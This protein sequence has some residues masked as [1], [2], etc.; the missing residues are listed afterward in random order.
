M[1]KDA[2]SLLK[3][4]PPRVLAA[5]GVLAG[6]IL[7]AAPAPAAAR[8]LPFD[9]AIKRIAADISK[10][11]PSK[12]RVLV[13]DL[14]DLDGRITHFGRYLSDKLQ[15]GL[16]KRKTDF[17]IVDR[18]K[19][20][21]SLEELTLQKAGLMDESTMT[22][23]GKMLGASV[24]VYGTVT[25]LDDSIDIDVKIRDIETGTS[26][27]GTSRSLKKTKR[28]AHLVR[29]IIKSERDKEKELAEYRERVLKEIEEDRLKRIAAIKA[30][31]EEKR[32]KLTELDK[33]IRL[34]STAITEYEEKVLELKKSQS[35]LEA[36]HSKIDRLNREVPSKLKIGMTRA[37]VRSVLELERKLG[38][39]LDL[40]TCFLVGRYFLL[41]EGDVLGSVVLS[42]SVGEFKSAH[43]RSFFKGTL[44]VDS[45]ETAAAFGKNAAR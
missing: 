20:D 27:G 43:S 8:G 12:S 23:M 24:I 14:H 30:E 15:I 26:L 29:S 28:L 6:A 25:D 18:S 4:L 31:E 36:I 39:A 9:K 17:A 16:A 41:F 35:R 44:V 42:G 7:L 5:A 3:G 22:K 2:G 32:S 45:C 34:K 21:L 37:Q 1:G 38:G 19:I 13:A 33:E 11:L 40:G 10:Q